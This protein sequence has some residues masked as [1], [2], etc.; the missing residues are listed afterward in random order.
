MPKYVYR[1]NSC[2]EHF[3]AVH[4]MTERQAFCELCCVSDCLI[5]VPQ[6]PYIKTFASEENEQRFV[7]SH[8]KEAIKENAEILKEQKKEASSW[9]W[10]ED[11]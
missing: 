1:C 4:G 7:G 2:E 6:M 10:K 5:R 3:T 8:V 11:V 9:E